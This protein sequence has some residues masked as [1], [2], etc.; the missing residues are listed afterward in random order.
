M[1]SGCLC[2]LAFMGEMGERIRRRREQL[3]FT[4]AYL[5]EKIGVSEQ[6]IGQ[7]ERGVVVNIRPENMMRL[8]DLLSVSQKYLIRGTS[9]DKTHR[10]QVRVLGKK[11]Q[12]TGELISGIW[13]R[14]RPETRDVIFALVKAELG[15][16][17]DR[18]SAD[19]KAIVEIERRKR[20]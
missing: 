14:L 11:S 16:E 5:A 10:A 15:A 8:T 12:T 17:I 18:R 3:G 9:L 20:T 13:D 6:V 2:K 4:R 19:L 1:L 7:W